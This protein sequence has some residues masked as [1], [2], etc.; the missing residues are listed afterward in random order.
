MKNAIKYSGMAFQMGGII[1][2]G[3]YAGYRWD[4]SA[5]RWGNEATPWATVGCTL[6][7]TVMALT[8]IVRQVLNDSK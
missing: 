7:A 1:A 6:L 5:G 2:L 3:A 4:L 8:L